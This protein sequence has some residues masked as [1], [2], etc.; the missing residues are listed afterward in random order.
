[1][2]SNFY[3]DETN[4]NKDYNSCPSHFKVNEPNESET[5]SVLPLEGISP[6]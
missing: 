5:E 1:M 2:Y 3:D 6:V 4:P